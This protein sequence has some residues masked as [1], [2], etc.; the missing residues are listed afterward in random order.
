[1]LRATNCGGVESW[2]KRKFVKAV[3]K[4]NPNVWHGEPSKDPSLLTPERVRR[5]KIVDV[6]LNYLSIFLSTPSTSDH[7]VMTSGFRFC[8]QAG[9]YNAGRRSR[10]GVLL[11]PAR[12]RWRPLARAVSKSVRR[13]SRR[14]DRN[15][16]WHW[17]QRARNE[18]SVVPF[19][20]TNFPIRHWGYIPRL[21]GY[22]RL[23]V[24]DFL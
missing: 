20:P 16:K 19:Y 24:S 5:A 11:D 6:Y 15:R 12:H 21:R 7:R 10:L 13:E 2:P 17:S 4:R 1:M 8:K 23:V 9:T 3:P 14:D 18:E 22:E